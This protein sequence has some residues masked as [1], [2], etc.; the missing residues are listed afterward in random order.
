MF[1]T[2]PWAETKLAKGGSFG[3]GPNLEAARRNACP[4]DLDH[5]K[6]PST[7]EK[8]IGARKQASDREGE[9][10]SSMPSLG[11]IGR[12]HERHGNYA[13]HCDA[14]STH[15]QNLV[16]GDLLGQRLPFNFARVVSDGD[17][18]RNESTTRTF[19]SR[20]VVVGAS[21]TPL[22]SEVLRRLPKPKRTQEDTKRNVGT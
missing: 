18:R 16:T 21:D 6:G 7:C 13:K 11:G 10:K 20:P 9:H 22:T 19:E 4:Y 1:H 15:A 17:E 12:H 3:S 2:R 8:S 14:D 5:A